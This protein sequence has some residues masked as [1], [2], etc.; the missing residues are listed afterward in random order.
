MWNS[1]Y[2]IF[3]SLHNGC[4]NVTSY[5]IVDFATEI[6]FFFFLLTTSISSVTRSNGRISIMRQINKGESHFSSGEP[7]LGTRQIRRSRSRTSYRG[8][9]MKI[10]WKSQGKQLSRCI[11]RRAGITS[12][13]MLTISVHF[14]HRGRISIAPMRFA[15]LMN[16]IYKSFHFF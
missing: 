12:A 11:L 13:L 3:I 9:I 6:E 15:I 8:A 10:V 16:E 14:L 7:R 1:I 5:R 2:T 4:R